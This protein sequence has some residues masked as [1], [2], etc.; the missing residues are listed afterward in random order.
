MTPTLI[1]L[2][3]AFLIL[4]IYYYRKSRSLISQRDDAVQEIE[5]T[6]RE[7]LT[8]ATRVADL[9]GVDSREFAELLAERQLSTNL[10]SD[11]WEVDLPYGHWVDFPDP[12]GD[13]CP[14]IRGFWPDS[15]G[16]T[17]GVRMPTGSKFVTHKHPWPETLIGISGAVM[18]SVG[19]EAFTLKQNEVVSIPK[20]AP[21]AVLRA[22]A[23]AQFLCV[24]G[25]TRED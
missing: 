4:T 23:P 19:E 12:D 16:T 22:A 3:L 6:Q 8:R 11:V 5:D 25:N 17:I 20:N 21:H 7:L 2:S 9:A 15:E 18:V 1:T 10:Q 13:P 24:W 14:Q